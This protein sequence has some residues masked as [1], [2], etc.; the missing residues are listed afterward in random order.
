MSQ[1]SVYLRWCVGKEQVDVRLRR[2]A[3][4]VPS[5]GKVHV[6]AVTDRQFETMAVFRGHT[7]EKRGPGKPEQLQLF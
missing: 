3:R 2:I 6:L 1:F 4:R 7:R 5:E